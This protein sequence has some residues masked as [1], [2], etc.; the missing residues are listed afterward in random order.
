MDDTSLAS[1]ADFE[2]YAREKG[3]EI[4]VLIA[5]TLT[6][7]VKMKEMKESGKL[8]TDEEMRAMYNFMLFHCKNN[9][10]QVSLKMAKER[11]R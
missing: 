5:D 1:L 9:Q 3:D 8:E 11:V 2:T 10:L 4:Y 7:L 6:N